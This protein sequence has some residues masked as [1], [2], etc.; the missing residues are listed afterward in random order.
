MRAA[1]SFVATGSGFH[2]DHTSANDSGLV[3][4]GHPAIEHGQTIRGQLFIRVNSMSGGTLNFPCGVTMTR[5]D[6]PEP[7]S[8]AFLTRGLAG[9]ALARVSRKA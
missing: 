4:T 6:V 1:F 3:P 9:L 7:A 5:V 2:I 8:L